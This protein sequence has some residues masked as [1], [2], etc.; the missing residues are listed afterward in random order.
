MSTVAV[1]SRRHE[2]D[3]VVAAATAGD[4]S[5]F[6]ELVSRYRHE[7]RAHTYRMLG[8]Y[9]DSEDLIQETFLRAWDKRA[10]F[11]G[12]SSFRAWLYRIATNACLNALERR[13]RPRQ[14][15]PGPSVARLELDPER[16]FEGIASSDAGPDDEVESKETLELA[17][18]AAVQHLPARQ[19]TV[20]F[21]TDVLGW[22]AKDTADL[23]ETSVA[24]VTSALQRARATLRKQLPQRRLDWARGP[25]PSAKERAL[26]QRYIEAAERAV[27]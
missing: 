12:D 14:I 3:A 16:L 5:A 8:S 1:R 13:A 18:L 23:L 21:L 4:R 10:S 9:E 2:G 15:V 17:V 26:L 6:S 19:R 11:R 25:G 27:Q 20:L 22:P 24:S 7:L